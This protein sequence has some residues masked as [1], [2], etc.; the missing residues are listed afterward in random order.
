MAN[1]SIKPGLTTAPIPGLIRALAIPASLGFFFNTMFNV[2]DTY[3]GGRISTQALAAL[4]LSFPVFFLIIAVVNGVSTGVTALIGTAL[5]A[6]KREEARTLAMQGL[7]F[8]VVTA[9]ALTLIGL[10]LSPTLFRLLGAEEEYLH[11]CLLYM[12]T[13]FAGTLFFMGASM[14]NAILSAQ[15]DTKSY[16]NFLILGFFLNIGLDPWFIYGGFGVPALGIR[17]VAAATVLVQFMGCVY[18][19]WKVQRT[20]LLGNWTFKAALPKLKPYTDIARQGLPSSL[21]FMTIAVG[22]FIL[23]Y[24][25]SHYGKAAVAAYGI[26]LRIEQI[27]LLPAIGLNI[28]TLTLVAQNHGARKFDRVQAALHQSMRYAAM[29]ALT[30]TAAVVLFARPLMLLFSQNAEVIAVGVTYL[31]IDAF[32]FYGYSLLSLH[33]STLQGLKK[34]A[35]AMG[36]GLYRQILAPLPVLYFFTKILGF[37]ILGIWWGF[38]LITWSAAIMAVWFTR[39]KLKELERNAVRIAHK[40]D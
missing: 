32:V 21:N 9:L 37:G 5:G 26:G 15:G 2:V 24:F 23:T 16:R 36:I 8:G 40:Q 3:F 13:I 7:S 34:P 17:G 35:F 19:S 11:D 12:D 10:D 31:R 22:A 25:V 14:L 1:T 20:G 38:F 30:G 4:S 27:F 39:R 28:A 6:E 18:L 29:I 33:T